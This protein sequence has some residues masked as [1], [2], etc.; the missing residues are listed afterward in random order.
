MGF[1]FRV[2]LASFFAGAATASVAGFYLLYKDYML[3]QEAISQQVKGV[4][5]SLSERIEALSRRISELEKSETAESPTPVERA[6][7]DNFSDLALL[8]LNPNRCCG[9]VLSTFRHLK[10][11]RASILAITA[12]SGSF[13]GEIDM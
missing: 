8:H 5:E 6:K 11:L 7:H 12:L 2:R 3:G 13:S 4:S 1:M 10:H 9:A